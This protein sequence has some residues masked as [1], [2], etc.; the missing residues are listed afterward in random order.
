MKLTGQLETWM[1]S[2]HVASESVTED[3]FFPANEHL[4]GGFDL[5]IRILAPQPGL[6]RCPT[7]TMCLLH[8][9]EGALPSRT[10]FAILPV[11]VV[12]HHSVVTT[13]MVERIG[14]PNRMYDLIFLPPIPNSS[15]DIVAI[16][17]HELAH[18]A[19][20]RIDQ[21]GYRSRAVTLPQE[22]SPFS[23]RPVRTSSIHYQTP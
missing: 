23:I 19:H 21:D 9:L 14:V 16:T 13:L 1:E 15:Q 6:H 7:R 20:F 2:I 5:G 3:G 8:L 12:I 17:I 4:R 10:F 11:P 18:E 22:A